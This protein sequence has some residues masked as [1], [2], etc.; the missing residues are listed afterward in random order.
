MKLTNFLICVYLKSAGT[1]LELQEAHQSI[2]LIYDSFFPK[3]KKNKVK[4]FNDK[5][6]Y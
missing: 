2:Q 5:I 3:K 1:S 6:I 4:Q